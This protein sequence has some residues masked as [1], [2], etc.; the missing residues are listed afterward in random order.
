[1]S[2]MS[3]TIR[4]EFKKSDDVRDAGYRTPE[5]VVRC[6]D[7]VYGADAAW[8]TLDVYRPKQAESRKLP[9]IVSIH[10]GG[11]VYGDKERYQYYC[12][13]L[14][15]RGFAVV[16]FTYRLA[17][18]FKYPAALEDANSVFAWV[19]ANAEEYGVDTGHI[20]GVGDSAGGHYM[21]LYAA[22]CTNPDYAAEY[23]FRVPEGL[24][25][26]A[27]A[28][29][30]GV[31]DISLK[32]DGDTDGQ[33]RLLMAELLPEQGSE[34][35]LQM[36][37]LF[38]HISGNYPPVFFMTCPGDFLKNQAAG[39]AEVLAEKNVPFVYRMYG[40]GENPLKH[41]FHCDIKMEEAQLCNEEE[42][43]FFRTFCEIS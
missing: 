20:F 11:W 2:R 31:Y 6:D 19:L 23:A 42:C 16:N 37:N 41:V 22:I 36:I 21:S 34:K 14:A 1:M 7:I 43:R 18:E 24:A 10:G 9:V 38:S 33:T 40:N 13:D 29:N 8:Q 27:I 3:D 30:C 4:E 17:P 28:L 25:L 26:K 15:R 32:E 39:L 35:E 5:D 12:M